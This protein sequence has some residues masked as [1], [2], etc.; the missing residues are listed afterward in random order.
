MLIIQKLV[1]KLMQAMALFA[2]GY[3]GRHLRDDPQ[4]WKCS[5]P[6][7]F[8]QKHDQRKRP[9]KVGNPRMHQEEKHQTKA[10]EWQAN[11]STDQGRLR[12]V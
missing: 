1:A 10:Y 7:E 3:V 11:G 8:L 12:H 6:N 2:F 4:N 9:Q 5:Q